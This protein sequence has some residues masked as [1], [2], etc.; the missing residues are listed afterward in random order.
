M[1]NKDYLTVPEDE[2]GKLDPV[3]TVMGGKITY[4]DPAFA[5]GAGLP[6]V[7]YQG[8]RTRWKRGTPADAK[9]GYAAGDGA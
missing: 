7:G 9:K 2:I 6:T 5:S 1:L 8:P 4:S 3:L